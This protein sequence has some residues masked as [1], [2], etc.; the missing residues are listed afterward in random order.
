MS[1]D[2]VLT[3]FKS[4]SAVFWLSSCSYL[5][6]WVRDPWQLDQT[7]EKPTSLFCLFV[8][9]LFVVFCLNQVASHNINHIIP[10]GTNS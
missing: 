5:H 10:K 8:C 9:L 6:I 3:G 7:S 2:T 4:S 1:I